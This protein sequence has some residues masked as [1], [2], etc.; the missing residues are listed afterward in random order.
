LKQR[1]ETKENS[2]QKQ[3]LRCFWLANAHEDFSML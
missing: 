1:K 2:S 3:M